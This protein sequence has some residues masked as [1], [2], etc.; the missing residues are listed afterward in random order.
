MDFNSPIILAVVVGIVAIYVIT[1]KEFWLVATPLLSITCWVAAFSFAVN[2]QI[3]PAV[4]MV[5]LGFF[6]W[7]ATQALYTEYTGYKRY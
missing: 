1:R 4:G 6:L 3:L 7:C 2:F 5:I